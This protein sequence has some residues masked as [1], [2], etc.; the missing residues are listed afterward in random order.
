MRRWLVLPIVA[1][2]LSPLSY[3]DENELPRDRGFT[4]VGAESCAT[5]TC[6]G[7]TTVNAPAWT[8]SLS[9][10]RVND[11]HAMA[12]LLLLDDDSRRIVA[13]LDPKS[14]TSET[15]YHNVLRTRCISCH[16]TVQAEECDPIGE[17]PPAIIGNGVSCETCHGAA[18]GWLDQHVQ[19]S[20][21]T[22]TNRTQTG[23]RETKSILDRAQNCVRCHIGSRTKD[24]LVR[25]MNHDLI[26]AG[27]PAL[28]FDLLIYHQN[29]PKHWDANTVSEREFDAS[30][31]RVRNVGRAI[32]LAAAAALSAERASAHLR[33]S[34]SVPWPELA[35]YDCF[36]CHQALTTASY[37][38]PARDLNRS[39]LHISDG[40]PVWNAWYSISQLDFRDSP[41][42]L[43]ALSPHRNDPKKLETAGR[44]VA[45][46]YLA[47]AEQAGKQPPSP[48]ASLG[49][50]TDLLRRRPPVDWHEAA[51]AYLQIEAVV[52]DL[53]R[54]RQTVAL[55][56]QFA[57]KLP[58]LQ[59]LLRFD[60]NVP[61]SD[62]GSA[63]SPYKFDTKAFQREVLAMF[64]SSPS[65][66][67][68]AP[69][70]SPS[71]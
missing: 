31:V 3:G 11:P 5:S 14:Q 56:K 58:Q 13:R 67:Q 70:T 53:S 61:S 48:T 44:K 29:L 45:R 52:D 15:A 30:S 57:A 24:G 40:L 1:T 36:A 18:S 60:A 39:P 6:H 68:P 2:L 19:T 42:Y 12:G 46:Y 26:A 25:D 41:E 54:R 63:N 62:A 47:K 16:A 21:S 35:D 22:R 33:N 59:K 28:R 17:I 23:F 7:G 43:I 37:N 49:E 69:P 64:G 65:A 55:A 32:G 38:L 4:A 20:W 27:H 50:I 51:I 9:M 34:R 8:K 71:P 10:H 66:K